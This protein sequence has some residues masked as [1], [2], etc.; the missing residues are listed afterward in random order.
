MSRWEGK[1]EQEHLG[2]LREA[3]EGKKGAAGSQAPSP[4]CWADQQGAACS[5]APHALVLPNRDKGHRASEATHVGSPKEMEFFIS[6]KAQAHQL[7]IQRVLLKCHFLR[8]AL[9]SPLV[10]TCFTL[11]SL[12]FFVW[13]QHCRYPALHGHVV[14]H[15]FIIFFLNLSQER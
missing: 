3:A 4:C 15:S 8:E 12:L 7:R 5:H 11:S 1:G 10:S 2:L 14:A 9:P 13:S 6:W